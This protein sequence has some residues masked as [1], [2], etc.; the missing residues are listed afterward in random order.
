MPMGFNRAPLARPG[1]MLVGD[2]GI[3]KTWLVTEAMR[4]ARR[5]GLRVLR[6]RATGHMMRLRALRE[7]L[8]SFARKAS[9]DQRRALGPYGVVLG[10]LIPE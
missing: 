5:A 7:S 4:R 6:G 2:A 1:L 10:R 3:G 9:D 8:A